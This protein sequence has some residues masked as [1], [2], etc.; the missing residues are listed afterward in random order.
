MQDVSQGCLTAMLT[1]AIGGAFVGALAVADNYG[2]FVP[3]A[4]AVLVVV[5]V[6]QLAMLA[7]MR[8]IPWPRAD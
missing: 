6:V 3:A 7:R 2:W 1:V 5:A 8:S 4:I